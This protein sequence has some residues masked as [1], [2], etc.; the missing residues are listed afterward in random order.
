MPESTEL[1]PT[2]PYFRELRFEY[3]RG[4]YI[5][6]LNTGAPRHIE[7]EVLRQFLDMHGLDSSRMMQGEGCYKG[8]I[9]DCYI[10]PAEFFASTK[11]RALVKAHEQ[12]SV[13]YLHPKSEGMGMVA[14]FLHVKSWTPMIEGSHEFVPCTAGQ[15]AVSEGYTYVNGSYHT[16]KEVPL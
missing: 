11:M 13:L 14:V 6:A 10:V 4:A 5:F 15:A 8:E 12:E 7:R 1:R 2:Y 16:V 3:P 9:E